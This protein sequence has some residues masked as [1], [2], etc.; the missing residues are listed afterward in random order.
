MAER[1]R[2]VYQE[3]SLSRGYPRETIPPIPIVEVIV[4]SMDTCNIQ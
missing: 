4:F 1:Y 3:D 2:V